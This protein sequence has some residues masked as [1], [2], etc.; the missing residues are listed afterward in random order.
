MPKMFHPVTNRTNVTDIHIAGADS[1][2]FILLYI[3]K[4]P[5][6]WQIPC[7]ANLIPVK[8]KKF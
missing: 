8:E 5:A 2:L 4:G 3:Q 6:L 1:D 7:F